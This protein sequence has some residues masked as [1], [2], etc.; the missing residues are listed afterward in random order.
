VI[1]GFW[2]RLREFWVGCGYGPFGFGD[3][4]LRSISFSIKVK[5]I[6]VHDPGPVKG[7]KIISFLKQKKKKK[8][9]KKKRKKKKKKKYRL[10]ENYV[11]GFESKS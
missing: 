2:R 6:W 4:L 5:V 8:K 9:K 1:L 10:C 7:E 3:C 11:A